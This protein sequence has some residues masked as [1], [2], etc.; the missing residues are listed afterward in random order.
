MI[1]RGFAGPSIAFRA[2]KDDAGALRKS[3]FRF[4]TIIDIRSA[5]LAL[6]NAKHILIKAI[7]GAILLIL[8]PFLGDELIPFLVEIEGAFLQILARLI[9]L[10]KVLLLVGQRQVL[11]FVRQFV[12]LDVFE[13]DFAVLMFCRR[14]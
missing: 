14:S 13:L 11:Q 9:K 8:R 6:K 5:G 4:N 3:L 1:V 2:A 7:M 10:F 12:L